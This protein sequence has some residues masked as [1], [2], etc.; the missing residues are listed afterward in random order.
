MPN[1]KKISQVDKLS[2]HLKNAANFV[3]VDF[4]SAKHQWLETLRR[5]LS[6]HPQTFFQ[7]VKNS[8]LQIA[9][10]RAGKK[11]LTGQD[12]FKGPSALLALPKDWSAALAA[13]YRF[14]KN[15]TAFVFKIGL[16]DGR[17]YQKDELLR[18]AQLPSKEVLMGKIAY[19]L[20]SPQTRLVYGMK[21]GMIK[22]VSIIK[23]IKGGEVK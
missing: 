22:I 19:T 11:E 18:L 4:G 6:A 8:L 21:F 1:A 2:A 13:F 12:Y 10:K 20:K 14:V 3:F 16:I 5:S 15:E 23:Q 9:L 17:L 7:V